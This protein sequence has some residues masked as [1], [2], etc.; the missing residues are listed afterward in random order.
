M[1]ELK[2]TE[3]YDIVSAK[4]YTAK[5]TVKRV[6]N[7]LVDLMISELRN[8]GFIKLENFGRFELVRVGGKDE[9]FT[10]ELGAKEKRWVD[11]H[12][13]IKFIPSENLLKYIN[14]DKVRGK[15]SNREFKEDIL[16]E[17]PNR[18]KTNRQSRLKLAISEDMRGKIDELAE[19]KLKVSQRR[20]KENAKDNWA[21]KIECLDNGVT[22][23]SIRQCATTL[24]LNYQNL[25]NCHHR[26]LE[27]ENE[28]FE[29]GGYTF[30]IIKYSKIGDIDE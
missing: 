4:S 2:P 29:F 21:I 14:A 19:R 25:N 16:E 11:F 13:S 20:I 23:K 5:T 28:T 27:Q 3:I 26:N 30:K 18:Y 22:Y 6:W 1:R 17:I 10:N 12:Y 9:W 7:N 8:I 24:K 15:W